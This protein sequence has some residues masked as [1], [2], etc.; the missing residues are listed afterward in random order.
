MLKIIG[1][2]DDGAASQSTNSLESIKSANL[3]IGGQRTLSLFNDYIN[4]TCEQK[5]LTG[6]LTQL[7]QWINTALESGKNVVVLA[8]GDPLCHGIASYLIKKLGHDCCEIIPN[9]STIQLACSKVGLTWQDITIKSVHSKDAGEWQKYS[10]SNH[11]LYDLL[12]A[13]SRQR[14]LAILTSPENTP[15]RI[16]RMML[17]EK[18]GANFNAAVIENIHNKN[19]RVLNNLSIDELSST[20]FSSPNVLLL[21]KTEIENKKNVFGYPDDFFYQRKPEK[22]LITKREVRAVSLARMQLQP[23]STVWDIGAGSGSVGLE[24]A[25][26]CRDGHVYAIEKNQAD[27]SL[28]EKNR[29]KMQITNYSLFHGKAPENINDWPSPDAV[30][31]GGSGGELATLIKTSLS[32]LNERGWLIMNFVTFENLNTALETLKMLP[33]KWDVTQLQVSRSQPIL[34]MHRL[35]AENSVWIVSAQKDDINE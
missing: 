30:F 3:I 28:I 27:L 11:G 31:V 12:Q 23:D 21:W 9:V 26:I 10:D 8:T 32:R 22:G 29:L 35:A 7:P 15:D 25:S 19:Q 17:E 24:A 14:K 33:V 16:G 6:N 34:H 20:T 5:D 2:L 1:V 4:Q 13:I 18:L